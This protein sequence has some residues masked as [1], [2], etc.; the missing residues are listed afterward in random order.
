MLK[1]QEGVCILPGLAGEDPDSAD[2]TRRQREQLRNWSLQQ[3][4]ELDRAKELQSLQAQRYNQSRI[5]LDNRAVELQKME[6]EHKRATNII[7]K[8]FNRA[9]ALE[10]R[11][12]REM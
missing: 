4:K 2:R 1:K 12:R 7:I 10:S 11:E 3:Q 5:T 9:L 8:N 6:Q